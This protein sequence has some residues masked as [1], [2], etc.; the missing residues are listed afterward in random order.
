MPPYGL[1]SLANTPEELLS[2]GYGLVGTEFAEDPAFGNLTYNTSY[3]PAPY[4]GAIPF[5]N[6]FR[7]SDGV[8]NNFDN[9]SYGGSGNPRFNQFEPKE[10][11]TGIMKQT[12]PFEFLSSAYEDQDE[13]AEQVDYLPGQKPSGIAKLF[14]FLGNLPT[15]FNLA[16][17]GLESL[18]GLNNRIQNSDFG[19]SPTIVDYLDARSYGGRDARDRAASKTMREAKA[20]QKQ[21]DMRPSSN[22][23]NQDRGRGDRPGGA[24]YSAPSKPSRASSYRDSSSFGRSFHD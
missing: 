14:E 12:Q 20:I 9:P 21:V 5:Q 2:K 6:V 1:Y 23:T 17:R 19:Q 16:R 11:A 22:Q 7:I 4:T 10:V 13:D 24:N 18:R 8:S 15:P 3:N